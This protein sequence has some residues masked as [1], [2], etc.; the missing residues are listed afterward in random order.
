VTSI[1]SDYERVIHDAVASVHRVGPVAAGF[2]A[3]ID[4]VYAISE[5]QLAALS[6]AR[7]EDSPGGALARTI[8]DR[9]ASGRGGEL[10][11][12]WDRGQAWIERVLGE[13]SARQAGGNGAQVAWTLAEIGAASVLCLADRSS[14]QLSVL[15][16]GILL[17]SRSGLVSVGEVTPEGAPTKQPRFILEFSKG[18]ELDGHPLPRSTRIMFGFSEESLERDDHFASWSR[19]AG[20]PPVTMLSG[21]ATQPGLATEDARW[22]AALAE[23][24]R[25]SGTW[26]HH[27]LSEFAGDEEMR[28]AVAFFRSSSIGMSVSELRQA[29][30]GARSPQSLALEIAN[31]GRFEQVVV[32]ADDWSMMVCREPSPLKRDALILGNA[33][34]G[35]RARAGR[36]VSDPAIDDDA[37]FGD[38]LPADGPVGEGWHCIA[39]PSPYTP[40]PRGTVG[41]G[42]SFCAGLLLG[43]S[44][45]RAGC[46]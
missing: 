20:T 1:R 46:R 37:L 2:T 33:L 10:A 42:D 7:D 5:Q 38:D 9:I 8:V 15:H 39:V 27:E 45:A 28:A 19:A 21:L 25:G 24:L 40:T 17:A 26:L 6:A 36:P 23:D 41:L 4:V 22:A 44:I 14:E 18:T 12:S 29:T 35:A 3:S 11:V 16:P 13:P 32:H 34:A 30:G 43:E 31:A